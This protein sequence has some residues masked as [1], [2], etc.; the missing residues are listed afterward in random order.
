MFTEEP[1]MGYYPDPHPEPEADHVYPE[2]EAGHVYPELE[3]GD[4]RR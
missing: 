4:L 3:A 1:S 2:L